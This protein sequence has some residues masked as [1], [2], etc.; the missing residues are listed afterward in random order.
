MLIYVACYTL[1]AS[2][3]LRHPCALLPLSS[4]SMKHD[5]YCFFPPLYHSYLSWRWNVSVLWIPWHSTFV[6]RYFSWSLLCNWHHS[7]WSEYQWDP[8]NSFVLISS[9]LGRYGVLQSFIV[10]DLSTNEQESLLA[11]SSFNT[12]NDFCFGVIS[13]AILF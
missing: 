10:L 9:G 3:L 6:N 8:K 12:K 5:F 2:M 11:K 13:A 1:R 7:V 4:V